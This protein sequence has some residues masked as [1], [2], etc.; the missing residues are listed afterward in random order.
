MQLKTWTQRGHR[1]KLSPD[2]KRENVYVNLLQ[3]EWRLL[4]Q[5]AIASWLMRWCYHKGTDMIGKI[6]AEYQET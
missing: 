4:D 1:N 6:R 5:K 3:I 2:K